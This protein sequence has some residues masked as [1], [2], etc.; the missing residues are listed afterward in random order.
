[1]RLQ[2]DG[3]DHT[4]TDKGDCENHSRPF[5]RNLTRMDWAGTVPCTAATMGGGA[6]APHGEGGTHMLAVWHPHRRHLIS[7]G[8]LL[9]VTVLCAA[10]LLSGQDSTAASPRLVAAAAG[11][12]PRSIGGLAFE[13]N[14][15]QVDRS[16]EFLARSHGFYVALTPHGALF[17]PGSRQPG[18][19]LLQFA[20][21][22]VVHGVGEG[23]LPRTVSYLK[24][25]DPSGWRTGIPTFSQIRYQDIYPG[26]DL[27]YH[28][29]GGELEYDFKVAAAADPAQIRLTVGGARSLKL[30]GG[31]DLDVESQA[32]TLRMKAP[33]AFQTGGGA[34]RSSVAAR[35]V[36]EHGQARL[37]VGAYDRSRPLVIDPVFSYSS[38]LGGPSND[39]VRA[40]AVDGAGN[41]YV[42]GETWSN[43][44]PTNPG[45][46]RRL[47]ATPE[48]ASTTAIW[49]TTTPTPS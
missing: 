44:F 16:V 30:D 37:S 13:E 28:T 1:M 11:P 9:T 27:V 2:I 4:V 42:T 29:N 7:V 31:G 19:L 23:R 32:G 38:F 6:M 43:G 47:V 10:A 41:A 5:D 33:V 45:P 20:G 12:A 8:A 36:V 46:T 21:S 3:G 22:S 49:A 35:F 25:H 40:I 18:R 48:T 24:G 34:G 26:V 17:F 39:Y 15:G 14:R